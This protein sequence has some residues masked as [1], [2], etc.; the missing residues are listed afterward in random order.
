M[1]NRHVLGKQGFIKDEKFKQ[2][3]WKLMYESLEVCLGL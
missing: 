2:P 3:N 1:E